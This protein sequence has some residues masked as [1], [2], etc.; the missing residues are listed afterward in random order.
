MRVIQQ[1][2][3]IAIR[4]RDGAVEALVVR[5]KKDPSVWIFPKGHI[6]RGESAAEAAVRELQEEAGVAGKIVKPVGVLS[7]PSG[8]EYVEVTYFLTRFIRTVPQAEDRDFDWLPLTE[9]RQRL[10]FETARQLLDEAAA[11]F[12]SGEA[13]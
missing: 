13:G 9:A 8:R 3:A 7:F 10:S 6:D 5:S 12:L 1:A 2:G 11:A 4:L